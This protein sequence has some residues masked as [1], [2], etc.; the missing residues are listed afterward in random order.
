MLTKKQILEIKEHLNRAQNP[1]FFFDNDQ[2]G[3]CSFLL[4]QRYIGRGKGIPIRSF[5]N[6]TV[7]YFKRVIELNADYIFILD[8][9]LVSDEFL[10]E[11]EQFNIPVI[12]I[13]HHE[14]QGEIPKFV[15]YY[16]PLFNKEKTNEPVTALC[17]QIS[18][19]KDDLWIAIIGCI[20][21]GFVPDFYPEF[22]K[23]YPDL[24]IDSKKAFDVYYKSQIGK[25]ARI[26]SFA[27]KDRTTNVINMLK[28]LMKVKTPHKVLEENTKNYTMHQRFNQ[29]NERYQKL[30]EKAKSQEDDKKVLFF[31]YGGD[32]SISADLANELKYMF[33]DKIIVVGYVSEAKIN[34]SVRG[35]KIREIVLDVIKD[36]ED[37]TGGGH[38]GAVGIRI[39]T[40][41]W[42]VFKEGLEKIIADD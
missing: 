31:K 4:L 38:E 24:A 34:I 15:N 20:S 9:P 30:L 18:Q 33:P 12:W 26:F 16:N 14:I 29:I 10:K 25:I 37:S 22:E 7:D 27:L 39:R 3:L 40:K 28:F 19:K 17:Y 11:V 5:P 32:L 23:N 8:K 35:N 41:D 21:D 13:D 2:D 6:L 42:E 1:L 36:L